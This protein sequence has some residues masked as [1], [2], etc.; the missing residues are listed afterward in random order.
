MRNR[1]RLTD[2]N[3]FFTSIAIAVSFFSETARGQSLLC[4]DLIR[5]KLRHQPALTFQP[6]CLLQSNSNRLPTMNSTDDRILFS[7][8]R[9]QN[10][11][12]FCIFGSGRLIELYRT[13]SRDSCLLSQ[14]FQMSKSMPCKTLGRP[15]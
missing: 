8:L 2:C 12:P 4:A 15:L 6:F 1:G 5:T 11:L 3:C 9:T 14:T 13:S 10:P 7:S